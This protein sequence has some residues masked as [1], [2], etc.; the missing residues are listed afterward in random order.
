MATDQRGTLASSGE[1]VFLSPRVVD[2]TT[3]DDFA[4]QLRSLIARAVE[5]GCVLDARMT[6]VAEAEQRQQTCQRAITEEAARA[7]ESLRRIQA[8]AEEITQTESR[9]A[10]LVGS[11]G[12]T[13][14]RARAALSAQVDSART[15]LA[16]VAAE[17]RDAADGLFKGLDEAAHAAVDRIKSA[18]A[19]ID[20]QLAVAG[21]RAAGLV[22]LLRSQA[23]E[24]TS[25]IEERV[26]N[27]SAALDATASAAA[28]SVDRAMARV[29]EA[30]AS[31]AAL[32]EHVDAARAE[33]ASTREGIHQATTAWRDDAAHAEH[34]FAQVE[35]RISQ[36]RASLEAELSRAEQ[37]AANRANVT[38]PVG[39]VEVKGETAAI[40]PEL[41][42]LA[43]AVE[44]ALAKN[45][46]DGRA[47]RRK[48]TTESPV[49]TRAPRASKSTTRKA[50]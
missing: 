6:A 40:A 44:T 49:K 46:N 1:D 4:Q 12:E 36:A 22:E 29:N 17:A 39:D 7:A 19:G 3:F 8:T 26:R 10:L 23:R 33:A 37:L 14:E 25:S 31:A 13:A 30:L 21:E 48:M 9:I 20:D 42:R 32:R 35:D 28:Q 27:E 50:A 47:K 45:A 38:A 34:R 16:E 24:A 15:A 5:A 43:S 41:L 11:V 18:R 2:Q